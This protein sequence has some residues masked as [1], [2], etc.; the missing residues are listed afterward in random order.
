MCAKIFAK[1]PTWEQKGNICSYIMEWLTDNRLDHNCHYMW[2]NL[3]F[4]LWLGNKAAIHALLNPTSLKVKKSGIGKSKPKAMLIVF[5][6]IRGT[7]S[8]SLKKKETFWLNFKIVMH[9]ELIEDR[10][11]KYLLYN[12]LK[13]LFVK[14]FPTL[15]QF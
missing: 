6:Y 15:W 11:S 5:L 7:W 10:L 14:C 4:R 12:F 13:V 9:F 2:W 8:S 1:K 3:D